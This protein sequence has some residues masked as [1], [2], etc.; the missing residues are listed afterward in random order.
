MLSF[1]TQHNDVLYKQIAFLEIS[2]IY[3]ISLTCKTLYQRLWKSNKF[4]T[5]WLM[6]NTDYLELETGWQ[7]YFKTLCLT[8]KG[9]CLYSKRGVTK[10]QVV[11][12]RGYLYP[13][14]AGYVAE[15]KVTI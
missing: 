7:S 8:D 5:H 12:K 2:E 4:W 13:G 1:I 6:Y 14:A 15:E 9:Q 11:K 10:F 3:R